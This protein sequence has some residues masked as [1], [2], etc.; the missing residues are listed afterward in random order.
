MATEERG[1]FIWY[2]LITPDS[3]A[4]GSFCDSVVGWSIDST[5]TTNGAVD[6][7]LIHRS[8]DRLAGGMLTLTNDMRANSVEPGWLGYIQVPDVDAAVHEAGGTVI[9]EWTL[10]AVGRLA[11]LRDPQGAWICVMPHPACGRSERQ[12][13]YVFLRGRTAAH[14]LERAFRRRSRR[15]HR[16]LHRH[17]RLAAARCHA[18]GRPGRI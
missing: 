7:H 1:H 2:E 16:L 18:D 14:L 6:Y 4:A 15:R 17:V 11:F 10:D 5:P 13:R 8:D 3:E 12:E 9:R